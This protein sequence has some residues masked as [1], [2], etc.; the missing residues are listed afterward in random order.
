[1]LE[2]K[3]TGQHNRTATRSGQNGNEA[4]TS[5]TLQSFAR[6]LHHQ[7]APIELPSAGAYHFAASYFVT[8]D[9]TVESCSIIH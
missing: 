3:H 1:M 5:T 9:I 6:W 2:V 7:C 4:V 8:S